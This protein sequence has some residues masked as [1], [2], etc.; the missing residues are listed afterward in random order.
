M[1]AVLSGCVLPA[2][3]ATQPKM[4]SVA[5]GLKDGEGFIVRIGCRQAIFGYEILER[6]L[7]EPHFDPKALV[8]EDEGHHA[9]ANACGFDDD[10]WLRSGKPDTMATP[11]MKAGQQLKNI[12]INQQDLRRSKVFT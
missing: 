3:A 1:A 12:S 8:A 6:H 9:A 5:L 2:C 10:R 4:R 7:A 11:G